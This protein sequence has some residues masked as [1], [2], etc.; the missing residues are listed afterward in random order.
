MAAHYLKRV[1]ATAILLCTFAR[2]GHAEVISPRR[3]VEVADIDQPV[4]SPDG[5]RVAFRVE[6]ASIERNTYDTVWYVQRVDGASSPVRVASGGVPLRDT[7]GISLPAVPVW[8]PDGRW[9]YYRALMDG[10]IEIWRAAA[11]GSVAEPVTRDSADVRKFILNG[12][13]RTLNYTVGA[14]REEVLAAEQA[15][16]DSGIH[17]DGSVPI[18]Q[19]LFRSGYIGGRLATQRFSKVW[20]DRVSLLDNVPNNWKAVDLVTGATR[21]LTS[22]EVPAGPLAASELSARLP[23]PWL[24]ASDSRSGRIALLTRVGDKDGFLEKPDVE[25]AMLSDK[26]A[27]RPAKCDDPLCM[28][29]AITGIQWRP[30]SDEVVFTVTDPDM[31]LA[32]SIFRWNVGNGAVHQVVAS[33]GLLSGGRDS[34]SGCGVSAEALV[35]VAAD[36][37]RPPRLER[38]DLETGDRRILFD[39]NAALAQD[40]ARAVPVRLLHWTDTAGRPVTGQFYPARKT[41]D[42]PSPLFVSYYRCDG[43][44]RGAYG[45]EWPL[46]SLAAHGISALCINDSATRVDAVERYDRGRQ[47]VEGAIDMLAAAGEI[48]R[49]K[50]GMGGLSFGTEV[51]L[52]TVIHSDLIA[53]ASISS[54]AVSQQYYLLGSM[55]GDVFFSGLRDYWQLGAPNETPERWKVLSPALNLEKIRCPI[56]MQVPEQEYMLSLDYAIPLMRAHRADLYVFPHEPHQKFQ[57]K[58]KLAVYERNLDWFRFWLQG[59]EDPNPAKAEQYARWQ[60]MRAN[61]SAQPVH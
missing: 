38:I 55:K 46:A 49:T 35:C 31:G 5:R 2:I 50:V 26:K 13:G 23:E 1:L 58:H 47:A 29:K 30:G 33:Q 11:D 54:V 3:L 9:I 57:P 20:F 40:M 37:G 52:W 60:L 56:L 17:I 51:T 28:Q 21:N 12:D 41:G 19:S 44:V 8:S 22:S 36:A 32:Q 53:A 6:Q 18:G 43:F 59:S 14:T 24:I 7:A 10:R 27:T 4:V 15:E 34:S 61:S 45:D 48:D 16:Y 42:H 39:P 25:L